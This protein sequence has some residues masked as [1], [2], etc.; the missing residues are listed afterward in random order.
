[1]EDKK[2]VILI[3]GDQTKWFEQ[4]IFILRSDIDKTAFPKNFAAE[5]QKI[6]DDYIKK[7]NGINTPIKKNQFSAYTKQNMPPNSPINKNNKNASL[8]NKKTIKNKTVNTFF[9]NTMLA[10]SILLIGAILYIYS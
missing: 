5:A 9:I 4:A 3:K 1:M 6:I 10:F 7:T 8:K 2:R